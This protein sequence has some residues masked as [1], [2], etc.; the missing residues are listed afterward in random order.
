MRE[1]EREKKLKKKGVESVSKNLDSER[2]R[3]V[4]KKKA[5]VEKLNGPSGSH[6]VGPLL[7]LGIP[8][9]FFVHGAERRPAP[10]RIDS[11]LYRAPAPAPAPVIKP[12]RRVLKGGDEYYVQ[13]KHMLVRLGGPHRADDVYTR[14]RDGD[15]TGD[16][17][18]LVLML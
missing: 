12:G 9:W 15:R 8:A 7:H 3:E 13:A 1:N 10:G 6:P 14:P 17:S 2:I 11:V 5:G 18:F 4:L 16:L